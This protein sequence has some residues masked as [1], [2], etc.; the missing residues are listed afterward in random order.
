[1]KTVKLLKVETKRKFAVRTAGE[2]NQE[3]VPFK[4]STLMIEALDTPPADGSRFKPTIIRLRNKA[5][6]KILKAEEA[7]EDT[8][9]LDDSEVDMIHSLAEKNGFPINDVVLAE[10]VEYLQD[11]KEG[12]EEDVKDDEKDTPEKT[13]EKESDKK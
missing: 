2:V 12:K 13:D 8:V 1:M 10:F 9:D 6:D 4:Y 11:V 7:E 3:H 5:I